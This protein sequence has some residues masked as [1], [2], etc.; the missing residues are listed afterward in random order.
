MTRL[1]LIASDLDGTLLLDGAQELNENTCTLIRKLT[2]AGILFTAASGRQYANLQRLFAPVKDEIAYICENGCLSFYRD[3][4][5]CFEQM[6]ENLAHDLISAVSEKEGCEVLVSGKKTS[7]ICP[8]DMSYYRHMKDVV[9]N[10]VTL[11]DDLHHIP[12]PYFKISL[13]QKGGLTDVSDWTE[14]FSGR[15]NVSAGGTE[16]LD[17]MPPGVSKAT[18]FSALLK[19][20]DIRAED[21]VVIGDN[22]ND[23]EILQAAGIPAAVRSARSD[24][25]SICRYETDTVENLL[26]KLIDDPDFL[27]R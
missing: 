7:W 19:K 22:E 18:A 13:Y 2:D 17:M 26:E 24:I 12:E 5:I 4:C 8:K 25:K 27:F 20:L 1:K 10:H 23:R 3:E 15:C 14:R 6:D 16:W 21:T 11:T 9:H